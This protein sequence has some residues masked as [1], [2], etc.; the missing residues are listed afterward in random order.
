MKITK[1]FISALLLL[2]ALY[3][4]R[5]DSD[6][7]PS[8]SDTDGILISGADTSFTKQFEAL[9]TAINT[10][11]TAWEL[12]TVDWDEVRLKYR[13]RFLELDKLKSRNQVVEDKD[14]ENLYHEIL[15]TLHDGHC[16]YTIR[17]LTTG[18]YILIQPSMARN[19]RRFGNYANATKIDYNIEYYCNKQTPTEERFETYY[20][21][22]VT[23]API[24]SEYLAAGIQH[25]N[26]ALENAT[27]EEERTSLA[28]QL[29]ELEKLYN[30]VEMFP[31][32]G[33]AQLI[34]IYNEMAATCHDARMPQ[35]YTDIADDI[36]IRIMT[37]VSN[38]GIA[39]LRF[40]GYYLHPYLGQNPD[41]MQN[42]TDAA[43]V[44]DVRD[45]YSLWYNSIQELHAEGILKGVIIDVRGNGGGSNMSQQCVQGVL[46]PSN[47]YKAGTYKM[48]AGTGRLDYSV[49]YNYIT[50]TADFPH[51]VID[52]VPIIALCDHLSGSNAEMTS[53]IIK[54]QPNG[55]VV[56][57]QTFGAMS[58]LDSFYPHT[59]AGHFGK[60]NVTAIAGF[61]PTTLISY[62]GY[63]TLEG[64]GVTPSE[65]YNLEFDTQLYEAEGRD[66]QLEAALKCIRK[67]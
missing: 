62:T 52:D 18:N 60:P 2:S 59:Y 49:D 3:S 20:D 13:P 38:D 9:W 44:R 8:Y 16:R 11:Y 26:E 33:Q 10:N 43:L 58:C 50:G 37:A 51:E 63:G 39:Y 4:C 54:Q 14:F 34:G 27:T 41:D 15:D 61:Q 40:S 55:V 64:I 7:I 19:A 29:A 48:K 22:R 56:G 1:L 6:Y 21:V 67:Q 30:S 12:E 24:I 35:Y 57:S 66:N 36:R 46:L 42:P 25:L 28:A 45:A 17:N 47:G 31:P 65:G 53:M 23:S 5:Q 32:Q